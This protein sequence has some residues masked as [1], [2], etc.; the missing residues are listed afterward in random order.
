LSYNL[1]FEDVPANAQEA[2]SELVDGYKQR[3]QK[4]RPTFYIVDA[5]VFAG[6]L[7]SDRIVFKGVNYRI[8]KLQ[9]VCNRGKIFRIDGEEEVS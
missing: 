3:D 7:V 8:V 1:L 2:L 4:R 9:D 5:R 6:I